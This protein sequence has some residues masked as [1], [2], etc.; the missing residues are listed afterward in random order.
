LGAGPAV[1]QAALEKNLNSNG[2]KIRSTELLVETGFPTEVTTSF[3]INRKVSGYIR[4]ATEREEFPIIFSG[5]CNTAALGTL[6]GLQNDAGVIW[7]DC[8]GDFNTPETTI[9]GYFDGM[10]LSMVTGECWKQLT[11]SIPGF[12][13]VRENNI[14]ILGARDF[15]PLEE[16]R[17]QSSAIALISAGVLQENNSALDSML[18]PVKSIYV[19]I[20]LDVLDPGFVKVSSYSAPGGLLP[21][22][23]CK[24]I[25]IIKK[26]YTISAVAFTSYDPSFD[27]DCKIKT[28][29]N[30]VVNIITR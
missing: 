3:E 19:H 6:S 4:E 7:F 5:N 18:R 27:P 11:A 14:M 13:P 24:A 1:L 9:G 29:V 28:V 10:A 8:H 21:E 15:D 30:D 22:E 2:H 25:S 20:D 17:L 23:L 12:K 26:K 16:K